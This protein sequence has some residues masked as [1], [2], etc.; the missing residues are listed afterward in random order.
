MKTYKKLLIGA[1]FAV[2]TLSTPSNASY[3]STPIIDDLE[4]R[5][6]EI[7]QLYTRLIAY[8][9]WQDLAEF[10]STSANINVLGPKDWRKIISRYM[11]NLN[12][13]V[14]TY[15]L[16]R[17]NIK[18]ILATKVSVYKYLLMVAATINRLRLF[19]PIILNSAPEATHESLQR[20]ADQI[21][22]VIAIVYSC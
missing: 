11:T 19:L 7:D 5:A 9:T 12:I 16:S 4:E 14:V 1:L 2:L 22:P 18:E 3:D 17:Q 6:Q 15:L 10:L 8:E 13:D 21:M 20:Y